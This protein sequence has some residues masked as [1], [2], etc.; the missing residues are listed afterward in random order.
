M[1]KALLINDSLIQWLNSLTWILSIWTI[2]YILIFSCI[3]NPRCPRVQLFALW[4][5]FLGKAM[6]NNL[7]SEVSGKLY[8]ADVIG[9]RKL[10]FFPLRNFCIQFVS[11]QEKQMGIFLYRFQLYLKKFCRLTNL[12]LVICLDRKGL[13]K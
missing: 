4:F 3:F 13:M 6:E 12:I 1:P 7:E 5:S 8:V 2:A 9:R 10:S 11:F